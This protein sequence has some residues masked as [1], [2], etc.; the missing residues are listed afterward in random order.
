[1]LNGLFIEN[2]NMLRWLRLQDA[3][4]GTLTLLILP[5]GIKCGIIMAIMHKA[6]A[7]VH[8]QMLQTN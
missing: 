1:M 5:R 4:A 2:W 3:N 7:R 8:A 6:L